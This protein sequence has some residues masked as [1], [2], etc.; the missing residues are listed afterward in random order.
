MPT[1]N[2]SSSSG[3]GAGS[4][5]RRRA[6]KPSATS[7][8]HAALAQLLAW[9]DRGWVVSCYQKLEPGDRAGD[10]Y[11]IKLKN[12]LRRAADRLDVLGFSRAEREAVH[13]A[14]GRIEEF[15]AYP[16]N[17][18]GSRGIAVFA[19]KKLLRAVRL[20]Y[21]LRSRVLVDR[22]P[23]V[24]EL[25]ALAESGSRLLVAAADR[26]SAR[27]FAVDLDGVEEL[28]GL[29]APEAMR[30]RRFHPDRGAA[31]GVGEYRFHSRIRE[32][33]H[34]H[35]ARVA[36]AMERAFR[37]RAFDGVVVGG[38]GVDAS[39]LLPHLGTPVRDAVIGVLRL[40]P[41]QASP[42]QIR[43]KAMELWSEAA[44]ANGADAVGELAGLTTSGWAVDGVEPA[45]RALARG[46]VRL[47]VVD[48]DAEVPGFRLAV[49]GRLTT[50]PAGPKAEGEPVPVSDVLDDAI[51]EALRQRA[52]VA[53]VRGDLAR[54]FD[55]LAAI[56]RFRTAR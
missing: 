45:L 41:R 38:M 7:D 55:R 13:E 34:R 5:A 16:A 8:V 37:G 32:E 52:R 51:E 56:V 44:E 3:R 4:P 54:R 30:S 1:K 22:T 46:Q 18:E 29:F 19:G 33:K 9:G 11:R 49:S 12:R 26:L 21:V 14:L 23:V 42:A 20:P 31:P 24:S 40:N 15:F 36:E 43:E 25:V 28:D 27:L 47:L 35:L 53:V 50:Q 39:A 2:P 48:H 17:L 6:A 10:K